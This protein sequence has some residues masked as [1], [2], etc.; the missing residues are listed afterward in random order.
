MEKF[1]QQENEVIPKGSETRALLFVKDGQTLV[2]PI[3]GNRLTF[4]IPVEEDIELKD[5]HK[6]AEE[7]ISDVPNY[8]LPSALSSRYLGRVGLQTH[9]FVLNTWVGKQPDRTFTTRKRDY[10]SLLEAA[11]VNPG[12]YDEQDAELLRLYYEDK[13]RQEKAATSQLA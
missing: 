1:T 10:E 9:G 2:T 5:L 4:S 12:N 7:G 11:T 3:H 6:V 13:L 8:A